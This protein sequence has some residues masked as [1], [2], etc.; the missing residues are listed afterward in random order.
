[1]SLGEFA[2]LGTM[3]TTLG[4]LL[5]PSTAITHGTAFGQAEFAS[6]AAHGMKLTWSPA[7][8]VSL[9]GTTTDIPTARAAGVTGALAP[10]WSMGGSQNLLDELRF[11]DGWDNAHFGD[12]LTAKDLVLMVTT[13]AADALAL[14]DR[15]GR[16]ETGY[17]ADLV[18][19]AGDR[20]APYDAVLKA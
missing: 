8:N 20:Q 15:L 6:M 10:D 5:A 9:Y 19:F 1:P 13:Q 2:T 14:G 16:I 4:C 7:S 11:A 12:S 18:V 3:T 17:L